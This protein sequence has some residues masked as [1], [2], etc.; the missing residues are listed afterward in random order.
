MYYAD[1]SS[2]INGL[3]ASDRSRSCVGLTTPLS[4]RPYGP[5][6]FRSLSFNSS[7]GSS[8]GNRSMDLSYDDNYHELTYQ[9]N[10]LEEKVAH[11]DIDR[12]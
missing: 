6:L 10:M 2:Q 3:Q 1:M 8:V 11:L 4:S 12:R 5:K 9:V 7:G